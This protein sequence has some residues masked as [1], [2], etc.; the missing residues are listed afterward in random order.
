MKT[1]NKLSVVVSQTQEDPYISWR[2]GSSLTQ[3]YF[4][5]LCINSNLINENYVAQECHRLKLKL[6]F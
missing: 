2:R 6:T 1:L 3:N 5:L 4:Y